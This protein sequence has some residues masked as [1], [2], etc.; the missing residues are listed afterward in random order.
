MILVALGSNQSGP[1]GTPRATLLRAFH[2]LDLEPLRL[3]QKS[4]IIE[5][6]AFGKTDQPDFVNAV[7]IV[8]TALGP[9][10]LMEHLQL[11]E[12]EAGRVRHERWGPRTLDL[13]LIDYES[14]VVGD[15]DQHAKGLVLPHPGIEERM[16]VL[17][18][19]LEIAPEWKHPVNHKTALEMIQKL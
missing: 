3:Y 5:T 10:Q 6:P 15:K 13:D 2:H 9:Q 8:L 7:A 1:W 18:P 16:F 14:L 17:E 4:S 12:Q 19:I 11:I